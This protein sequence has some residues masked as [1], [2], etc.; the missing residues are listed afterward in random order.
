MQWL[1][2]LFGFLSMSIHARQR[3]GKLF[4]NRV[5]E[6]FGAEGDA[7]SLA[8]RIHAAVAVDLCDSRDYILIGNKGLTTAVVSAIRNYKELELRLRSYDQSP[9]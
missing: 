4:S 6:H 5:A 8:M 9:W 3:F 7:L 1:T 2:V